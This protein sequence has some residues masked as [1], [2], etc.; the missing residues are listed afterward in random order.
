MVQGFVGRARRAH[1][2]PVAAVAAAIVTWGFASPLVKYASLS[3][4]AMGFYR[5]WLGAAVLLLVLRLGRWRVTRETLRWAAPAGVVFGG[6]LLLFVVSVKMTTVANATLIGAL[7]PAIVLLVASRWFGETVSRRDVACVALAIAGVAVV[8]VGSAGAPEWNPAG[9]A[10]AMLSVLMF[11]A[12]FLVSKQARLTVGTLEY[13]TVVHLT[14]AVAVTPFA[15]ARPADL[16]SF[17]AVD[18][19]IVLFFAFISGTAGQMVIGWAHRYVDVTLSSLMMLAVPVVAAATAWAMLG[20]A[21]GPVQIA[22]SAVT[23]VAIGAMVRRPAAAV[24]A[25]PVPGVVNPQPSP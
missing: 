14:A 20:E 4:P 16:V 11:T 8:I 6:N 9:D 15:L 7:Q 25:P 19:L 1:S 18:I 24:E 12:Y 10:L 5:L 21:L 3:G 13:M 22:G 23:L 17:D 2:F